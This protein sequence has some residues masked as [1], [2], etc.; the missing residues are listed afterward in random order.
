MSLS[1]LKG[2]SAVVGLVTMV[3]LFPLPGWVASKVNT[4][5]TKRMEKVCQL[6]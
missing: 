1:M 5:Q 4:V 2:F 6:D 3:A